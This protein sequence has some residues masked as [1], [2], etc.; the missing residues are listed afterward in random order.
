M[1]E[2]N[3]NSVSPFEQ[4][5]N[6]RYQCMVFGGKFTQGSKSEE[7]QAITTSIEELFN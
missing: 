3:N 1:T 2:A 6:L 5:E 7:F 4:Y